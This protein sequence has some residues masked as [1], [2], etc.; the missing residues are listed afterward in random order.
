MLGF[1][2]I[3]RSLST[4]SVRVVEVIPGKSVVG[5]EIPNEA[6]ELVTLSEIIKSK[7]YDDAQSPLASTANES[8]ESAWCSS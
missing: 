2:D 3:A 7:S 6:R 4:V 8:S 1:K 5:L